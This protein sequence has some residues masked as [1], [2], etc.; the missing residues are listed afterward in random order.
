MKQNDHP[1]DSVV[2]S[3]M[4]A[5]EKKLPVPEYFS[6]QNILHSTEVFGQTSRT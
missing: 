1:Y 5:F 3:K 4:R 6:V 2:D